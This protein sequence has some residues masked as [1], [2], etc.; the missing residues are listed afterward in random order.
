MTDENLIKY[1]NVTHKK[2]CQLENFTQN[3]PSDWY[4]ENYKEKLQKA[5]E[6]L[7]HVE[8]NT[9]NLFFEENPEISLKNVPKQKVKALFRE[10]N[11]QEN[12]MI[13]SWLIPQSFKLTIYKFKSELVSKLT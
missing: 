5:K 12:Q 10:Y 2:F 9:L 4:I 7:D 11:F 3:L 8:Q 13:F 1:A 6:F